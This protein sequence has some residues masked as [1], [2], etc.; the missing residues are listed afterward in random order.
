[1]PCG[2]GEWLLISWPPDSRR[3]AEAVAFLVISPPF[4]PR[5]AAARSDRTR[6]ATPV[7]GSMVQ[8]KKK[9]II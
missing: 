1:M 8:N 6:D 5:R 7:Q 2:A 3:R 4:S 9:Q